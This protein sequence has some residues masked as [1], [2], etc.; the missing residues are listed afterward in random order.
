MPLA[1]PA[2]RVDWIAAILQAAE[3]ALRGAV[4]GGCTKEH[5]NRAPKAGV[6]YFVSVAEG[7]IMGA[8]ATLAWP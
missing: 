1:S 7:Q 8:M 6:R 3:E 4:D 2:R 5:F